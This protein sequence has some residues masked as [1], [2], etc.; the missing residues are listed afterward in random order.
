MTGAANIT[1]GERARAGAMSRAA[2]AGLFP[3]LGV[4]PVLGRTFTAKEDLPNTE[5]MVVLSHELWRRAFGADRGILGR[6]VQVDGVDRTVIGV[7]P[8]GFDVGEERVE[9]W[10]P[11]ALDPANPGNRGGHYP[12]PGGQAQ[13]GRERGAGAV[14]DRGAGEAVENGAAATAT[15]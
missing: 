3:V 1:G 4:K 10:V 14:G 5:P 12:L 13:A 6:R 8:A 7:M 9:A 15:A 2:S 11:L